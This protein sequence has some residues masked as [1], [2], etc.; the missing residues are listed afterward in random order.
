MP[1]LRQLAKV[2]SAHCLR[3][4]PSSGK[5]L[6]SALKVGT[7]IVE[8]SIN[9]RKVDEKALLLS[10]HLCQTQAILD[11]SPAA[12]TAYAVC[13]ISTDIS[14]RKRAEE[15]LRRAYSDL[16]LSEDSLKAT[17]QEL[18]A[19]REEL[20]V[21]ELQLIKAARLECIGTLAAGAAHEV[22]NPLQTM[23]M[24][25]H[26]LT[27]NLPADH[28][29]IALTL[30]DMR[31]AVTRANVIIREL[32]ELSAGTKAEKQT[33]DLN[34]C[35]ERSLDLLHYELVATQTTVVRQL[36]VGLPPVTMDRGK[37]EQVFI[38]LILNALHAMS[39]GGTLTITSRAVQWS[40]DLASQEPVFRQFKSGDSLAVTELRDTGSG[41]PEN[42]LPKIFDPFFTTGPSGQGTGL[43]LAV[44]KRIVDLHG[45]AI[46]IRNAAP[47]GVRV[48]LVMSLEK[49]KS[50]GQETHLNH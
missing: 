22:K 48:T 28:E 30:H 25:L 37:M 26:Y 24:G 33:E 9:V 6:G 1:K 21:T 7:M 35:V 42:L 16:A 44:V 38:N 40:E 13:G 27:H 17:M 41:I 49:E 46:S 39:N 45:G 14:E 10:E 3:F 34:A 12:G 11:N 18:K 2:R 47:G 43:G 36:A 31:Q 15:Q 32:L 29:G 19:T 20:K 5:A 50:H 8:N 4:E 23:L